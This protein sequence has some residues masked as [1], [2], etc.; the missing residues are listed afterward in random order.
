MN[1]SLN[2]WYQHQRRII[3]FSVY[4]N[5]TI[6]LL[7]PG[8]TIVKYLKYCW[9][10][11]SRTI[12]RAVI[13][14]LR[15]LGENSRNSDQDQT[16][17]L[18][19]HTRH[20]FFILACTRVHRNLRIYIHELTLR[21]ALSSSRCYSLRIRY[22]FALVWGIALWELLTEPVR[23]Q[24]GTNERSRHNFFFFLYDMWDRR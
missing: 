3:N 14:S 24:I 12:Y 22:D 7:I 4:H 8:S 6:S 15:E 11:R 5:L 10:C 20:G 9:H 23:R 2:Y 19:S 17:K 21:G 1:A 13:A 18:G 16:S